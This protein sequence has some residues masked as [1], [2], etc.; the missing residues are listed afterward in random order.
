MAYWKNT[1]ITHEIIKWK[2]YVHSFI[3]NK[4]SAIQSINPNNWT[5]YGD[6]HRPNAGVDAAHYPLSNTEIAAPDKKV[7]N[8]PYPP[9][10]LLALDGSGERYNNK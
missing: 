10:A 2:P 1:G 3:F 8:A 4:Q 5:N 6:K 7:P 9:P